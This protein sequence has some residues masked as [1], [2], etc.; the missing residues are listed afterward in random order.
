MINKLE[1]AQSAYICHSRQSCILPFS[2]VSFKFST[3][4]KYFLPIYL[5][6][7]DRM[8]KRFNIS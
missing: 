7:F 5:N 3:Y 1:G 6:K 2:K 4:S 8:I